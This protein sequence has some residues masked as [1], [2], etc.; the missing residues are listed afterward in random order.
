MV[1]VNRMNNATVLVIGGTGF[2]GSNLALALEKLGYYVIVFSRGHPSIL[3]RI[4]NVEYIIGNIS[5]HGEIDEVMERVDYVFHFASSTNPKSSENDLVFDISSNLIASIHI[6]E[7]CVRNNVKKLIYCSSGGTVYGIHNEMPLSETVECKP[8]SSYGLV[9]FSIEN[10][11]EYFHY[12]YNLDYEILRLSNPFG[13]GQ[14]YNGNQGVI[15]IF[16]NRILNGEEIQ[17]FGNGSIIR[18]YIYIDDFVSLC[19]KLLTNEK[20]NNTLNVGSGKGVSIKH[21][22]SSIEEITGEKAK[23]KHLAQRKFDV[24]EIY[25][26]ISLA[27]KVYDWEPKTSFNEGLVTTIEWI[28]KKIGEE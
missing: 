15:A 5:N 24:P 26:D 28:R 13:I 27:K 21:I 11:I 16:I 2:V 3:G 22:I 9:K 19:L 12:K 8:I 25:L 23:I 14:S 20:K 1:G 10:Y 17:V 18:D 7:A 6:M 4:T